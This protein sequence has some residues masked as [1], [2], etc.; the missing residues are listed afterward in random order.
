M[1]F[2]K[3]E[4]K[5][6]TF[7]NS[8]AIP[9]LHM[10]KLKLYVPERRPYGFRRK[11]VVVDEGGKRIIPV[12]VRLPHER[13]EQSGDVY[14]MANGWTTGKNSMR[15]PAIEAARLGH[16]AVTFDYTSTGTAAAMKEDAH[17]FVAVADAL[18]QD[19]RR[20]GLG[21]SM[22]GAVLTEAMKQTQMSR[23]TLVSPGG[24]LLPH[25]Y[26]PAEIARRF[27]AET[28]EAREPDVWRNP[29]TAI[30]LGLTSMAT[31]ARRPRAVRAEL[32]ELLGDT[33][34][35]ALREVK[36]QPDAPYVRFMYGE[37]DELIPAYA[38][39][40]SIEGLPFDHVTSYRGGHGRLAYD[41]TLSQQIFMMDQQLPPTWSSGATGL[42]A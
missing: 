13:A 18:P 16:V 37:H 39:I 30:R 17:D 38:Q 11:G 3:S 7:S 42:A 9:F 1:L 31:C 29:R 33:V 22:G 40:A 41:P 25:Y 12:T 10:S 20:A 24:Y 6:I 21:L 2:T 26:T 15:I 27:W 34:H 5:S 36:A 32:K 19:L 35:N 14:V 4:H 8:I 23:A 28:K